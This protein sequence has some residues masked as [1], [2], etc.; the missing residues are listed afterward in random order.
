MLD[1]HSVWGEGIITAIRDDSSAAATFLIGDWEALP[2]AR[3]LRRNGSEV[4]LSPTSM[5]VLV[6][7]AQRPGEV[8]SYEDLLAAFWRGG[9]S[10]TNAVHKCVN[11]LRHAFGD[12]GEATYIETISK[13][14]YRMIAP[15]IR[16]SVSVANDIGKPGSIAVVRFRDADGNPDVDSLSKRLAGALIEGLGRMPNVSVAERERSLQYSIARA[17]VQEIG[18]ELSV[19]HIL[20]GSVQQF[21]DRL[22]IYIA[23]YRSRD[24]AHVY[25]YRDEAPAENIREIEER[26][27]G[28][29]LAA[30]AIHLDAERASDMRDRGTQNVSAYRAAV[31]A[32]ALLK[33][34][35]QKSLRAAADRYRAAIAHDPSFVLAYGALVKTLANLDW[36]TPDDAMRA[37]LRE[38]VARIREVVVG[39]GGDAD[40]LAAI[41]VEERKM[42]TKSWHDVE[43]QGREVIQEEGTPH[44]AFWGYVEYADLLWSGRLFDE[45]AR[46][47]DLYERFEKDNPWVHLRRTSL[48]A[49]TL[50]PR[51]AVPMHKKSLAL[52]ENNLASLNMLIDHLALVG[53]YEEAERYLARLDEHDQYGVWASAARLQLGA[54]RGDWQ[55]GSEQLN[56]ALS[57]PRTNDFCRGIA[58]FILGDVL[59]GIDAWRL[60]GRDNGPR[61]RLTAVQAFVMNEL[62]Y[63]PAVLEDARYQ[64]FMYEIGAGSQWTDYLREKVAELAPITGIAPSDPTPQKVVPRVI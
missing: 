8:V 46:Y 39:L 54:I 29:V 34:L 61:V 12:G 4:K 30:L 33:R 28:N 1:R 40:V 9:V 51:H 18:K 49:L 48:A 20:E 15:V 63:H 64:D 25:M 16:P 27:V 11:E 19:A 38:E 32:E 37:P 47:L 23:L 57:D 6:Y 59:A 21:N 7:L 42:D 35:D 3:R 52:F 45:A 43:R 55:P 56:V 58:H 10:S 31:E 60:S 36:L 24:A 17:T 22:R 14:G 5:N 50:G 2:D 44:R 62:M 13:R 26:S 53:E 41:E